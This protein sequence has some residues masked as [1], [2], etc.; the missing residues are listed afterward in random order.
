MYAEYKRDVSHNYLILREEEKVNTAS[1][2]VRM[3]TGN[4]IPSILKCRLQ[5]LDG[6]L[7][8]YYDITS[9]QSLASFYE[10]RK[11]HRK[12]LH[13]LFGGFIRVMEEMAEFLMN[14]DQLLLCPEYIFLDIEKREVKFCCLP[15][16]HHP[17]QEQF[18]ELTEYLLPR[19]DHEDSQAVS[20]GYGVYRKAMETGFQLEH[21]KE[22]IYQNRE[23]TEK[24]NDRESTQNQE[25]KPPEN[26]LDSMDNFGE[27]IQEKADVS[28]LLKTDVGNK[29]SKRKKGK[30]KEESDFQKSSN[31]WTGALL[32]VST[33]AVLIIFLILRY[34]GYLPGIPAEAIFGGAII[35]LALAAFLSW[36]AEKKKQKKQMSAEWRQKV[37]RELDD[38]YESSS[39]KRRT[40]RSSEDLY[41]ADSVQEK[42]PE[43]GDGKYKMPEQ[44][45]ETENYGETVVLSAGQTEG[46]ASLVSREPGELATIYLDRDLMV[47]GKMENAADAV[48]SL[49]TVSRIHAKI[50]KADDEYYLSDL[51]SR[52]GTSVNGRLLKTGEEYQLQDE[53]QVEFAQA[54]YIFLK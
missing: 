34:L 7:L 33:A 8:F 52:N 29:T 45:G 6:N 44:T 19:L 41:E 5:G 30:K 36:T 37:K 31:E 12:D 46:P 27:K 48:I 11:F 49:P 16:Y 18:R 23:V 43:W 3:L 20:M 53:D 47:I 26:N 14:T 15:D 17:I 35:L 42:M 24:S 2:Q 32:C 40:E 4:V 9:R 28:H 10:Q 38:T 22:A 39:E 1:Y 54:R 50:R 13:M 51:N 21:I 25:Q